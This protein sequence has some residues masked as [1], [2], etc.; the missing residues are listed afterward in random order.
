MVIEFVSLVNYIVFANAM[1]LPQL[2]DLGHVGF[3]LF[4][5]KR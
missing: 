5:C 4:T 2:Q 3:L 1:H